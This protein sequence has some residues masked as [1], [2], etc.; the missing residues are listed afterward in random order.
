[1]HG[2]QASFASELR[3]SHVAVQSDACT[4]ERAL[5]RVALRNPKRGRA[6]R[7][8]YEPRRVSIAAD[9]V[10]ESF[11]LTV[12]KLQ[13]LLIRSGKMRPEA[14]DVDVLCA[15]EQRNDV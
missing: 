2:P 10:V 1:H 6:V 14:L 7:R 5:V 3:W 15:I 8:M 13:I 9:D 11:E 12:G 4:N